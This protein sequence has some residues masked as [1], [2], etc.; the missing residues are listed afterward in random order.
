MTPVEDTVAN[1]KRVL[2]RELSFFKVCL[3]RGGTGMAYEDALPYPP[4]FR[5]YGL[6]IPTLSSHSRF[7]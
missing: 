1:M 7:T 4:L 2:D 3:E 6:L 5:V